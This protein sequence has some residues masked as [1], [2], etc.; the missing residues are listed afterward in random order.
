MADI[1]LDR[2]LVL[3][4][5]TADRDTALDLVRR[6][7]Q[8]IGTYKVGLQLFSSVGPSIIERLR[9]EDAD[10]FL[11]LKL[12]DI[13]S[14]VAAAVR[15]AARHGVSM[16][17]VHGLGGPLMMQAAKGALNEQ[18]AIP[19]QALTRV[20]GVSV[21][22]HHTG[23][24]LQSLGIGDDPDEVVLRLVKLCHESGL[25]GCV[26]SPEEAAAVRAA[27][28]E[29]F[30]IVCPGIRPAGAPLGDQARTATPYDA[31]K[32]GADYLVVGRPIRTAPDPGK[33]AAEI[34]EEMQRALEERQS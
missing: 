11:D 16:L 33:V 4:L 24:E 29:D 18:T 15:E 21:L 26:C 25:D 31:V 19:G 30:V 20:L 14:T 17:T 6:T 34:L 10:V 27:T 13:P 2:R 7:R 1:P 23:N 3:A 32:A 5:D 28:D 22:T 12:H 8:F 9:K